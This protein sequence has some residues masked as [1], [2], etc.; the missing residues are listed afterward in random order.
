MSRI[1]EEEN[2]NK[3]L[4]NKELDDSTKKDGKKTKFLFQTGKINN[5]NNNNNNNNKKISFLTS[6][7][8]KEKIKNIK[9]NVVFRTKKIDENK[10][11]KE[12]PKKVFFY[13]KKQISNEN[14]DIPVEKPPN[15]QNIPKK[16]N[17]IE[18]EKNKI[19]YINNANE[20]NLNLLDMEN[21][22]IKP[23]E[24]KKLFNKK[25]K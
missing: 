17:Y 23:K 7:T 25:K 16:I 5:N 9:E 4:Q 20:E 13:N 11:K 19:D 24:I 8:E 18:N 1:K 3:K 14:K 12:S 21:Y 6:Q 15:I 22:N 2:I 10:T